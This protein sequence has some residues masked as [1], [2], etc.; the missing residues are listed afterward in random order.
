MSIEIKVYGH[1]NVLVQKQDY[2]HMN[3]KIDEY[4]M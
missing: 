2:V 1:R 3:R 4:D